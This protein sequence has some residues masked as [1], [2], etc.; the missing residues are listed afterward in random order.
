M[1]ARPRGI[2][3]L[4][5]V[6]AA[7]GV[8]ASAVSRAFTPGAS[9]AE[10]TRAR[11]VR[12]A[13]R[14]GYKPN[15]Q[16]RALA[17]RRSGLIAW[18]I[19]HAPAPFYDRVAR[20][21]SAALSD[22]GLGL[23]ALQADP[24]EPESRQAERALRFRP[25]AAVVA[26]ATLGARTASVLQQAGVPV[27]QFGRIARGVKAPRVV[28][29]N[30]E[31]AAAMARHFLAQGFRRPAF[32]A[33]PADAWPARERARG[34]TAALR[35]AGIGATTIP[36]GDFGYDAGRL[37]AAPALLA[38]AP[39]PD[40][41]F[42]AGDV[43]AIGLIDGLRAAGLG[44]P[45]QLA[46]AGFDDVPAAAYDAYALT[47]LRQDAE[48]L[49]EA[50]VAS[51]RALLDGTTPPDRVVPARLIVRASTGQAN[52]RHASTPHA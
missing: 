20:T 8:S 25:E 21:L 11:V 44:V 34:F 14:L 3:T 42:C 12:A 49:A 7:A 2:V 37:R 9:I 6:A 24:D 40:A 13:N 26:S 51:L 27:L 32:A 45:G 29:D 17:T 36:A 33:G 10:A 22:A 41:V 15:L 5:D 43:I 31:A 52:A 16:A 30:A 23:I 39:R 1:N 35:A 28:S 4:A 46:V 48:G 19:P 38:Q 50:A 47:T 18:I